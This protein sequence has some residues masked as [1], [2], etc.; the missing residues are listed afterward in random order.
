MIT[1]IAG[2]VESVGESVRGTDER[3]LYICPLCRYHTGM[4]REKLEVSDEY[5]RDGGIGR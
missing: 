5:C 2:M 3:G 4:Q 1:R